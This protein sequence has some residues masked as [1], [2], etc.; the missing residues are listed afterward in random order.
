MGRD[1]PVADYFVSLRLLKSKVGTPGPEKTLFDHLPYDFRDY[2]KQVGNPALKQ[3]LSQLQD[4]YDRAIQSYPDYNKVTN[5]VQ[6]A[7]KSTRHL[8]QYITKHPLGGEQ[9]VDLL[10]RL[11][12]KE[13]QLLQAS[14]VASKVKATL[15]VGDGVFTPGSTK[16]VTIRLEN[17]STTQLT[18]LE[19]KP[20]WQ[21]AGWKAT[22]KPFGKHLPRN[23]K[24]SIAVDVTAPASSDHFYQ[25]YQPSAVQF[26]VSYKLF[27]ELVTQRVSVDPVK[28]TVAL[29]PDW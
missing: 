18:D 3:Q 24:L 23:G 22:V 9:Q 17:G 14:A 7:L 12:V 2:S 21:S 5:E 29:L 15:D 4:Q 28:Q 25:P 26:D 1:L 20:V 10:F 8:I 27:G 19:V 11:Q 13:K 6:K 16:Q